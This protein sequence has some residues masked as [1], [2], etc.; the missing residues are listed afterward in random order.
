[1]LAWTGRG[2]NIP[3]PKR[4]CLSCYCTVE[5]LWV[6]DPQRVEGR[7]RRELRRGR[8]ARQHLLG[9]GGLRGELLLQGELAGRNGHRPDA[10][11]DGQALLTHDG[12]AWQSHLGQGGAAR[13]QAQRG[14]SF[15]C[16]V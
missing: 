7:V 1:V 12:P 9:V 11:I 4:G 14:A 10:V 16:A 5:W 6:A 15:P 3:Y 13:G 2:E 8:L